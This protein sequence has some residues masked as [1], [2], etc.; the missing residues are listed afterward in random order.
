M[1]K[2]PRIS[3]EQWQVLA[4]VIE[5]GGYAR[6]AELLYKSQSSVT[7]A[8]HKIESILGVRKFEIQGRKAVLTPTS[9]LLYRRARPAR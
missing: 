2:T 8:M 7:Y 6:A 1:A 9:Q 3:L 4:T 5:A